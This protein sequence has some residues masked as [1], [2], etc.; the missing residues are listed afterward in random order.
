MCGRVIARRPPSPGAASVL[1]SGEGVH[2][3]WVRVGGV[4]SLL[5]G[6]ANLRVTF[7]KLQSDGLRHVGVKS[8]AL[9]Q[10]CPQNCDRGVKKKK[11]N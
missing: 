2:Q 9:L 5:F 4:S 3:S 8:Y 7:S 10:N 1:T 6:L 11:K